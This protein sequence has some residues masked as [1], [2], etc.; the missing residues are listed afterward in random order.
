MS[1][2][3]HTLSKAFPS[4]RISIDDE[5]LLRPLNLVAAA[6]TPAPAPASPSQTH[7]L[8]TQIGE[9]VKAVANAAVTNYAGRKL[10]NALADNQMGSAAA[11]FDRKTQ[12]SS[13]DD[14]LHDYPWTSSNIKRDDI[15]YIVLAEHRNTESTLMRQMQFYGKGVVNTAKGAFGAAPRKGLLEVYDEIFPDNPTNNKYIL[16]YFSKSAFELGTTKWEQM[17]EISQSIKDVAGGAADML[18][19]SS[20]TKKGMGDK[21]RTG[22]KVGEFAGAA[23]MTALKGM[24]PVVGIFDRPRVFSAHNDREITIEFPLYNTLTADAWK[25]NRDFIYR[26][27]SQNLYI[28]RDFITGIPPCFYR[29][30]VPQQYFCFAS[31]VTNIKVENLGNQ[32]MIGDF[33]VPDAYQV[34]ITLSEMVMPSLN[35]FQALINGDARG[36]V[37]VIAKPKG[38]K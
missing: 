16:P 37:K 15:P 14:I 8:S 9:G 7:D 28:K 3:T 27:M 32:R 29:V 22:M 24:Y 13:T 26:F 5:V 25:K 23:A 17:D 20:I 1:F 2:S 30:F 33:I 35:Q 6:T 4:Q 12:G 10:E 11:T 18:D 36:R 21:I 38:S 34:S 31:C 19:Q